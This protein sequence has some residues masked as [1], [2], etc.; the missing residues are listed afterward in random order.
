MEIVL[1]DAFLK[2]GD[3]PQTFP[4]YQRALD[5][6][7]PLVRRGDNLIAAFNTAVVN[8]KIADVWLIEG[9][10]SQALPYYEEGLRVISRLAAADSNNESIRQ[11]EAIMLVALGH[12]RLELGHTDDG[13]AY[14]RQ[15]LARL[16]AKPTS[17][18]I[19][20]SVEVLIRGW[21]GEA[22]EHQGKIREASH[23]YAVS[24]EAMAAVL[25]GGANDRRVQGF[26]A[27]ATVRLAATL[28]T[29]G[30]VDKAMRE[31][32]QARNLLEPL[33]KAN[34]GDHELAYVLAETYTAEGTIAA[35]RA[36]Q[37]RTQAERLAAWTAASDWF[38][39]SLHTWSTVPHP[40]RISTSGFEVTLPADVSIRLARC[41]RAIA[42]R[43]GSP[44]AQ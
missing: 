39:K 7:E 18:P 33:V 40:T 8:G 2:L 23:E 34:P 35:T 1:G 19:V 10:T 30:E 5:L 4:H 12:A 6:L 26:L 41:D 15:A 44:R 27:A 25:A 42:S 16:D 3:R 38:R 28:V 11:Q 24:K 36:E 32:A 20:R 13:V 29:L 17:T 21:L 37:A 31:Y 14:A 43:G 9:K 22:L